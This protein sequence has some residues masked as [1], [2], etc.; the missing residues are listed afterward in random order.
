MAKYKRKINQALEARRKGYDQVPVGPER[1]G[2]KRPGSQNKKKGYGV[3][4]RRR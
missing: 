1:N 3:N 2:M 4:G